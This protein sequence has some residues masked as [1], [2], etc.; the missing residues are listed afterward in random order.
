MRGFIG[1]LLG[2]A[3]ASLALAQTGL[4]AMPADA[5]LVAL[6]SEVCPAVLYE[7]RATDFWAFADMADWE[8]S[9]PTRLAYPT[10]EGVMWRS[11]P[12]ALRG[13]ALTEPWLLV[14]FYEAAGFDNWDCPWLVVPDRKPDT[15]GLG[16]QGL[17]LTFKEPG[18]HVAIMP[19]FGTR[20]FAQSEPYDRPTAE[21]LA[22]RWAKWLLAFPTGCEQSFRV[23]SADDTLEVTYRYSYKELPNDWNLKPVKTAPIPPVLGLALLYGYPATVSGKAVSPSCMTPYGPWTAL[24]GTDTVTVTYKLLKYVHEM[25]V[26]LPADSSDPFVAAAQNRLIQVMEG[27]F[28]SATSYEHDWGEDNFCWAALAASWYPQA[29]SFLPEALADRVKASLGLYFAD[30]YLKPERFHVDSA[31]GKDWHIAFGPGVWDGVHLNTDSGKLGAACLFTIW[32][33]AQYTGDWELIR[34]RWDLIKQLHTT[35]FSQDWKSVGRQSIAE[36]GDEAAPSLALARL[37][38]GVGD[39]ETYNWGC[40]WFASELVHHFVKQRG[41]DYFVKRQPY[42]SMEVIPSEVFLT[43]LW[44][45]TAGWQLDGPTYPRETDERQFNNRY[46]RFNSQDVA[47]FHR[48]YLGADAKR[49]LDWYKGK[50]W[51]AYKSS[52]DDAHIAPSLPR[53]YAM[54]TDM[55]PAEL[56]QF[57]APEDWQGD[58]PGQVARAITTIQAG[59]PREYQRLINAD[60]GWSEPLQVTGA[61]RAE[62]DVTLTQSLLAG[63]EQGRGLVASWYGWQ[64][65]KSPAGFDSQGRWCFGFFR[66]IGTAQAGYEAQGEARLNPHLVA[67]WAR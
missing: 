27:R 43:N 41:A 48:D 46:V 31:A 5:K 56:A 36:M 58:T 38:W 23:N 26:Q 60:A 42:A 3:L 63:D 8:L 28:P 51:T 7:V 44:G 66:T 61:W 32:S 45:D 52:R 11:T 1:V 62:E 17:H 34:E 67:Y 35:Q 50:S 13:A 57:S 59:S 49:E 55:P 40:Y 21:R 18:A 54:L 47:R 24:E 25:Q 12:Y 9:A 4:E 64:T 33:Y 10:S 39:L 14:D 65:P 53:L 2:L 37:A 20:K 19:L 30:Y 29:L 16:P 22:S 15:I 6:Q